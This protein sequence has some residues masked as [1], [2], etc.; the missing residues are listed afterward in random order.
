MRNYLITV[1]RIQNMDIMVNARSKKEALKKLEDLLK[2]CSNNKK[3][4]NNSFNKSCE[5]KYKITKK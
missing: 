5:Y 2:K 1:K 4:L 3:L